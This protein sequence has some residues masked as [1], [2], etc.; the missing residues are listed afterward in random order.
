MKAPGPVLEDVI[1]S[2]REN[3]M[4]TYGTRGETAVRHAFA[5]ERT[6]HWMGA[7]NQGNF[8]DVMDDIREL[9]A[10]GHGKPINLVVTSAGG[11]TGVAMSFYDSINKIYRPVLQTVGSGDV[12][13]AGVIVF[14][15]G[16]KRYVTSNTTMLLHMAGRTFEGG[17]R[18]TVADMEAMVK[19]DKLKDFQYA[20]VIAENSNGRLTVQK[21]LDM[22]AGNTILTSYE[23]LELG[24][25]HYVLE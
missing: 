5:P 14:L 24:L 12:D 1:M 17:K 3:H 2:L 21:V 15:A 23:A 13:S 25:A 6:I 18:Y 11:P 4:K 16:T 20:S 7:V 9:I 22:M 10:S 19:E 8:L